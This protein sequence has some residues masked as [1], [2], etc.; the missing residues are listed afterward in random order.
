MITSFC[1]EWIK[2]TLKHCRARELL[3]R[4]SRYCRTS[5]LPAV[6]GQ[7]RG[8]ASWWNNLVALVFWKLKHK[9]GIVSSKEI[10]HLAVNDLL[11]FVLGFCDRWRIKYSFLNGRQRTCNFSG[12][13]GLCKRQWLLATRR[14]AC[15]F[16]CSQKK[17]KYKVNQSQVYNKCDVSVYSITYS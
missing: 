12:V 13:A 8:A 11:K 14:L 5:M 9:F 7:G 4:G 6:G 3:W 2:R 1:N 16:A 10:Q 17:R 15:S